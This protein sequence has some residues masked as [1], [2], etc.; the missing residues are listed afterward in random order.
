M[1][2]V[3]QPSGFL[4]VRHLNGNPYNGQFNMYF[5]SDA[6]AM[7]IGDAVK[8]SGS[9]DTLG[10]YGTVVRAAAGN[11][12]RGVVIGFSNTPYL[13]ANVEDLSMAYRLA[14]VEMYVAVAD[15]PDLIFEAQED[16]LNDTLEAGDV[17]SIV[18]LVATTGSTLTGISGME[19]DSSEGGDISANTFLVLGLVDR[20]DN[21]LGT[22][23]KWN[24]YPLLHELRNSTGV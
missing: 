24:V 16:N 13:A 11:A 18:N 15:D 10:K 23:A 9:A 20:P 21:V 12:I 1:A 6:N 4:P 2:N 19:I 7:W 22:Y 14:S 3:D 17:G 5:V 8:S